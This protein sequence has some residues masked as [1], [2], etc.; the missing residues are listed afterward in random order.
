MSVLNFSEMNVTRPD[1][2]EVKSTYEGLFAA[3]ASSEKIADVVRDWDH[4]RNRMSTYE[5][6]THL[7]FSQDTANAAYK[8]EREFSDEL[9]PKITEL[10]VAMKRLL[11]DRQSEL[12]EEFGQHAFDL[13]ATDILTYEPAIQDDLVLESKQVAAYMEGKAGAKIECFGESYNLSTISKFGSDSDRKVRH[14]AASAQWKWYADN[15]ESNDLHYDKLVKLRTKMAKEL[16]HENYVKLGY[17]RMNRIDYSAADVKNFRDQVIEKVVPLVAGLKEEQRQNLGVEKLMV[18]DAGVLDLQGAP[19]PKG[20]PKTLTES[21]K[22]MFDGMNPELG[23]FFRLMDDKNLLDLVARDGKAGGGFCTSFPDYGVPFVFANFNGTKHDVEV[24][25]HEIGHAFQN[26]LAQEQ[27]ISD[28]YWPT[29]ESAEIHSMSLEFL[30]WPHMDKFFGE[31]AER[32]RK[33]HLTQSL[34]FM[35]YGCAVDH[36]Q[37]EIYENPEMS[38]ADRH[39]TWKK[40]EELYLPWLDWGDIEHGAMGGRW[41]AQSH[42]F[43]GPFYYIDYV[44]AMTCALQ[45]WDGMQS[46]YDGALSRYVTLCRRGGDAPFQTLA[47]S[48][49]LKSPFEEGC[50]ISVVDRARKY[51]N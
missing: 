45:F 32:F 49:G 10:D 40:M 16:G 21:A 46:D 39:Q 29:M 41:H 30:T 15:S 19:K 1:Y 9:G 33:V 35:P 51:L 2:E 5:A 28:Y 37:H 34:S 7:R 48:A 31:E 14:E 3:M 26:F 47:K 25:T 27:N 23:D 50:L 22:A 43:M 20:D 4:I 17:Q 36:F 24:F 8:A 12:E 42:I 11:L 44:L 13:W 6:I 38:P 18:W